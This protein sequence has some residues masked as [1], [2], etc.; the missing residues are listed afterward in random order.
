MPPCPLNALRWAGARSVLYSYSYFFAPPLH[1]HSSPPHNSLLSYYII[2][3]P[4]AHIPLCVPERRLCH[5]DLCVTC[6]PTFNIG[7]VIS[8]TLRPPLTRTIQT[9]SQPS[10]LEQSRCAIPP[11]RCRGTRTIDL[12]LT[13]LPSRLRLTF[14]HLHHVDSTQPKLGTF[15][16]SVPCSYSGLR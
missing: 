2:S 1:F 12:R 11:S 15:P 13:S 14:N 9:A 8:S 5:L 4:P 10:L 6:K 16:F 7:Q 3:P